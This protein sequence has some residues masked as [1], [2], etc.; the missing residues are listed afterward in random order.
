MDF[1]VVV[2]V[3]GGNVHDA[4]AEC[5]LLPVA[6]CAAISS[7]CS[8][9]Y[10]FWLVASLSFIYWRKNQLGISLLSFDHIE[11]GCLNLS[12]CVCVF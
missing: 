9:P 4:Q 10:C 12:V 3:A 11:F 5:F 8:N 7:F 6:D 2:F 1:G